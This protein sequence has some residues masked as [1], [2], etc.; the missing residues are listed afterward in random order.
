MSIHLG[1]HPHGSCRP[2]RPSF[3]RAG[4]AGVLLLT[5]GLAVSACGAST[6]A[7]STPPP[8]SSSASV[9]QSQASGSSTVT[10]STPAAAA[11]SSVAGSSAA[12]PTSITLSD[13]GLAQAGQLQVATQSDQ[14]PFDF[15]KDGKE[16]GFSIDLMNEIAKR[17]GV[18][19]TY[20]AIAFSGLLAAVGTKQYDIGA[21][22]VKV[23]ADRQ[24]TVTF[25]DPYYYGYFGII[26][27][28]SS[29][30]SG[31][32]SLD[33]KTVAVVTGSAQVDY[34]KQNF[35]KVTLKSF[36]D[37]PTAVAALEGGQVDAFFL[38][39]PDTQTYL[40]DH[41]DLMLV[42]TIQLDSANA[43]PV[44]LGNTGLASAVNAE[45]DAMYA[46]GTYA[47][48]YKVWFTQPI[49]KQLIAAHPVLAQF[50]K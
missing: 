4:A 30:L 10:Q 23:T 41:P 31:T 38:G 43:F 19:P 29:N 36:P 9:Q 26:A 48:I 16:Q 15:V 21:I 37:Q 6:P 28:K 18:Q 27:Q 45:L 44:A 25:T 50:N 3:N 5:I 11:P 49:P 42:A 24:K 20:K 47:K 13:L 46:D 33:G 12:T 2:A 40:Q 22:A 14:S 1:Q 34:A 8:A 17:L 7:Q 32:S 35:P 39:G